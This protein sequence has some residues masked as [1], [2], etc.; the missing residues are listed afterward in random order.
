[1]R[2]L[3]FTLIELLVVIATVG[4]LVGISLPALR[5]ARASA[6][7]VKCLSN[8]RQLSMATIGYAM[9]SKDE[10]FPALPRTKWPDGA[11]YWP[12]DGISGIPR[13]SIWAQQVKNNRRVPGLLWPYLANAQTMGECPTN[14]RRSSNGQ[15][16]QNLW[17]S[18]TGVDFDYTFF[19]ETEGA[20][21][22]CVASVAYLPPR[23]DPGAYKLVPSAVATLTR[24]RGI[25]IFVEESTPF[26]NDKSRDGMW[27]NMD[28]VTTRHRARRGGTG[29][30]GHL[31]YLDGSA[32]FFQPPG[33]LRE[34]V[35]DG[36]AF[37]A[38]YVYASDNQADWY[39][40]SDMAGRAPVG[41]RNWVKPY[42]FLN[43]PKP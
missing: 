35:E 37:Q 7:M 38:A 2:R 20:K 27:G 19:D 3:G 6:Q 25:P 21:L 30:G 43:N 16:Q 28:Q 40:V 12:G 32:G 13:A 4:L 29:G 14:K 1:M 26:N 5:S 23:S 41:K 42:G 24:F 36:R 9:D 15:E 39:A 31:A 34:L 11:Q 18:S 8:M 33:D 10:V 22:G 17:F